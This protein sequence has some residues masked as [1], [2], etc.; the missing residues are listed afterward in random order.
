MEAPVLR[1]SGGTGYKR[2]CAWPSTFILCFHFCAL[3][4]LKDKTASYYA[5]VPM[6]FEFFFV[7]ESLS[8]ATVTMHE[9]FVASQVT[10]ITAHFITEVTK[11]FNIFMKITL[12]YLCYFFERVFPCY[13]IDCNDHITL[14]PRRA[15]QHIS[16]NVPDNEVRYDIR[17][18]VFWCIKWYIPVLVEQRK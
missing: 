7:W 10:L 11:I 13:I 14:L 5:S 15:L 17:G 12:R 1:W 18:V 8:T 9:S 4:F 16:V 2:V 3:I 6:S